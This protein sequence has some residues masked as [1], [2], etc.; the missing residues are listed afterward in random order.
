MDDHPAELAANTALDKVIA[1]LTAA[2]AQVEQIADPQQAFEVASRIADRVAEVT[3]EMA[4]LTAGV[5]GRQVVRIWDA[6]KMT[7]AELGKRIGRTK[8]RAKQILDAQRSE[9]DE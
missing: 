7:L 1:D 9:D 2:A 5:R 4:A 6:E 8:Q 3:Q